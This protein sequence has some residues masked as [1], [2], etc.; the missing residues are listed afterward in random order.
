MEGWNF[1]I[2]NGFQVPS[3]DRLPL[4]STSLRPVIIEKREVSYSNFSRIETAILYGQG[5]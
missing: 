4:P 2:V 1:G 5:G 3:Q